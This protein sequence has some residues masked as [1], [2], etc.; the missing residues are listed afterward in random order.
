MARYSLSQTADE[1]I[2]AIYEYSVLHFGEMQA[3]KYFL[4]MHALFGVLAERPFLGRR[5]DELGEG[6]RRVVYKAHVIFYRPVS[7][8]ILVVDLFGVRQL[9]DATRPGEEIDDVSD[10]DD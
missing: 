10:T 2:T 3:D 1:K 8:G 9:L 6:T 5:S 7:G 4:G